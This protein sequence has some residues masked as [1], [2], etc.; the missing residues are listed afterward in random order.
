ML[1]ATALAAGTCGALLVTG[2]G[3]AG[4]NTPSYTTTCAGTPLGT[5]ASPTVTTGKLPASVTVK[6]AF[7]LNGSSL[8]LTLNN[9][10]LLGALAGQTLGGTVVTALAAKGAKPASQAITYTVKPTKI[11]SPAPATLTLVGKG[12]ATSFTASKAGKVSVKTTG[13]AQFSFTALGSTFGPYTCT[14]SPTSLVIAKTVA[15]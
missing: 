15:K 7:T 2:A 4:A 3:E 1:A 13:T 10:T 8:K 11:P 14:S 9:A 6:T 12:S 5:L